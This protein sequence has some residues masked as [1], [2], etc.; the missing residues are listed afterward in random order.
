MVLSSV[1]G[2]LLEERALGTRLARSQSAYLRR[3]RSVAVVLWLQGH[4]AS[5][6]NTPLIRQYW[7]GKK[8]ECG[9]SQCDMVDP[10]PRI[11]GITPNSGVFLLDP[12]SLA[13]T[14]CASAIVIPSQGSTSTVLW[15]TN[16]QNTKHSSG[17]RVSSGDYFHGCERRPVISQSRVPRGLAWIVPSTGLFLPR[18][19]GK[20][21][22]LCLRDATRSVYA[23]DTAAD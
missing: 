16:Y 2:V 13:Y 9:L 23:S 11:T 3:F 1:S 10:M 19:V 18:R 7:N 15:R 5:A 8:P 20:L 4:A 12:Q 14:T 21:P 17:Y 6:F 22:Q